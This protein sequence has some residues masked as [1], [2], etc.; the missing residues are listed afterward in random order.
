[1]VWISNDSWPKSTSGACYVKKYETKTARRG[2]W[3]SIHAQAHY[4]VSNFNS[5]LLTFSVLTFC[6][7][8]LQFS[9]VH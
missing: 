6:S 5:L 7:S 1:L 2:Y 8:N 4:Q 3:E 9:L